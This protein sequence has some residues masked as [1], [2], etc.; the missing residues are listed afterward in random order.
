MQD[1][2]SMY[3]YNDNAHLFTLTLSVPQTVDYHIPA[4]VLGFM[5]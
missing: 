1:V 3:S 2:Q 5:E 4:Q